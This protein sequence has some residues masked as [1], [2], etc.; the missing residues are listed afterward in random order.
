MGFVISTLSL[1]MIET[2]SICQKIPKL[3]LMARFA[4][5]SPSKYP[6]IGALN[7]VIA[8]LNSNE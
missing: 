8:Q 2:I 3:R 1:G 4:Q 7:F 6:E 5:S